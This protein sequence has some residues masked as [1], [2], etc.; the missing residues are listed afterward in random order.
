[1][2]RLVYIFSLPLIFLLSVLSGNEVEEIEMDLSFFSPFRPHPKNLYFQAHGKM[3]EI[4]FPRSIGGDYLSYKGP[5]PLPIY[6][7]SEDSS[8]DFPYEVV[9]TVYLDDSM[10]KP[11]LLFYQMENQETKGFNIL[12]IESDPRRFPTGSLYVVNLTTIPMQGMIGSMRS[13]I[14]PGVTGP[15]NI[16]NDGTFRMGLAFEFKDRIYP[17]FLNTVTVDNTTR[18]WVFIAPPKR[19]TSHRVNVRFVEDQSF[20]RAGQ[21]R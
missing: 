13:M 3:I 10:T 11:M 16:E 19:P 7:K 17:A 8:L 21:N 20:L 1:M 2:A 4:P 12:A 18:Q 6:K 9:N 5:N 14:R 15:F